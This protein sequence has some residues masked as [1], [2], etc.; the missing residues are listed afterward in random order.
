M[1]GRWQANF[2]YKLPNGRV[3]NQ[4]DNLP[5]TRPNTCDGEKLKYFLPAYSHIIPTAPK[6][7]ALWIKDDSVTTAWPG[8]W[9][10]DVKKGLR[11]WAYPKFVMRAF[12]LGTH[13][14]LSIYKWGET[15]DK[16]GDEKH[17]GG[18]D[19]NDKNKV[20]AYNKWHHQITSR[21]S[22]NYSKRDIRIEWVLQ[23][24][25]ALRGH[26]NRQIA[27]RGLIDTYRDPKIK[28]ATR[29]VNEARAK[30]NHKAGKRTETAVQSMADRDSFEPWKRGVG[31][32]NKPWPLKS[33]GERK[34]GIKDWREQ[35]KKFVDLQ[36]NGQTFLPKALKPKNALSQTEFAREIPVG[37]LATDTDDEPDDNDTE[38]KKGKGKAKATA[39]DATTPKTAAAKLPKATKRKRGSGDVKDDDAVEYSGKR[40]KGSTPPPETQPETHPETSKPSKRKRVEEDDEGDTED[41]PEKRR[42]GSDG[43]K[44]VD[45]EATEGDTTHPTHLTDATTAVNDSTAFTG[46]SVHEPGKANEEAEIADSEDEAASSGGSEY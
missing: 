2:Q 26:F 19:I 4:P 20:E 28:E 44:V 38:T 30:W 41:H 11:Q 1:A 7:D 46:M 32:L 17:A 39:A 31:R 13:K 6:S 10:R 37:K 8:A 29:L 21:N 3:Y 45:T 24:M 27:E 35:A 16:F 23:E 14:A 12:D 34:M 5:I 33:N 25:Q 36:K 43:G 42:K 15:W 18:W 40:H 9:Y 22:K